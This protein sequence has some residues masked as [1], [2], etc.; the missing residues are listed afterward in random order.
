MTKCTFVNVNEARE[1]LKGNPNADREEAMNHARCK[2]DSKRGFTRCEEHGAGDV[3]SQYTRGLR[4][5]ERDKF[6]ELY[7]NI[8]QTYI[9]DEKNL[10]VCNLIAMTCKEIITSHDANPEEMLKHI[11]NAVSL[12]SSLTLN[13]KERKTMRVEV[14]TDAIKDAEEVEA[15]VAKRIE[16]ATDGK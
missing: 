11:Q 7:D 2:I 1:F 9:V 4:D 10:Y 5:D 12:G 6:K 3:I 13:P 15:I 8:I 14:K 16:M